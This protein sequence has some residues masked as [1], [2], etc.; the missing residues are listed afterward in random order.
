MK[1]LAID[2]GLKNIGLALSHGDLA[3][4]LDQIKVL[5]LQKAINKLTSIC[6]ENKIELV[7]IGLPQGKL[8]KKI[9][10]FA[11]E[12]KKATQLKVFFQ[13]ETLTSKEAVQKM[14]EAKKPL[15]KRQSQKHAFSACLIL[16]DYLDENTHP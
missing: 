9:K 13:D 11:Q 7:V 8:V 1:I 4:P 2:F 12:L 16:Q 15:K 3:E 14:V 6:Q 10:K 5:D